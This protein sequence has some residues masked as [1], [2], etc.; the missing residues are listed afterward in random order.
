MPFKAV[1]GRLTGVLGLR[2]GGPVHEEKEEAGPSDGDDQFPIQSWP[3][4]FHNG[5]RSGS[6][7][8]IHF[9]LLLWP[10][11]IARSSHFLASRIQ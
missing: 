7:N 11:R 9:T 3:M 2:Y 10:S 8:A 1:K 6:S 5:S 4:S